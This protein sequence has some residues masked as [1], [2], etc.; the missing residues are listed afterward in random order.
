M[1]GADRTGVGYPIQQVQLFNGDG[2]NLVQGIDN[3][4]IAS[5]LGFEDINHV[6]NGGIASNR[7]ICRIDLVFAHHSFDFLERVSNE[8]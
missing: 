4:N 2:I 5:V 3:G 1:L 6:V 7:N 8:K